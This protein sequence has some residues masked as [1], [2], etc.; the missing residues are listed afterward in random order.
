MRAEVFDQRQQVRA[1]D[2]RRR[3]PRPGRGATASSCGCRAGRARSA[4][5]RTGSPAA[6]CRYAQQIATFC[7]MPRDSSCASVFRFSVSSNCASSRSASGL[8][9]APR[10][11]DAMNSQVLPDGQRVEQLRVVRHVGELPLGLRRGRA[12]RRARRRQ[13]P[14]RRRDDAGDRAH[15]RRLAR[16]VG[17]EQSEDLPRLHIERQPRDGD[18]LVVILVKILNVNHAA[19]SSGD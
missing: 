3:R 14:V 19:D 9:R 16:A 11:R 5:R 17:P 12:R 8:N 15:R 18:G 1:D 4:A 7:R 10:T 2:H 13:L 6:S